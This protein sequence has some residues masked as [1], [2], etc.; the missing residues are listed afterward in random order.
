[1]KVQVT[2]PNLFGQKYHLSLLFKT[3]NLM[4]NLIIFR[5]KYDF[6]PYNLSACFDFRPYK[7]KV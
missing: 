5:L 3:N 4:V 2:Y 1:M 7:K 6:R